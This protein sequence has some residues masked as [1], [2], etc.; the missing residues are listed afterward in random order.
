MKL[1][2][3]G[4]TAPLGFKASGINCG[5]KRNNK[6]DLALIYSEVPAIAAAC[7]TANRVQSESIRVSKTHLK[8]NKAQAIIINSGNANCCNGKRGVDDAALMT[9]LT[10]S[11]LKLPKEYV[12]VASTGLI[13]R[14]LPIDKI[15]KAI[16]FL[17][18]ELN[19]NGSPDAAEA[20]MTTD[21][22]SKEVAVEIK[23]DGFKIN[24]GGIAKGAGMISPELATMLAFFTTDAFID[25]AALKKIFKTSVDKSFNSITVDGDMSTND[26]AL[27]F[28][29]GLANNPKIDKY[30]KNS[31]LFSDAL[32][33]VTLELAK[34][35]VRDGEGATKFVEVRVKGVR[36]VS[37][38]KKIAFKVANS[39][40]VKTALFGC[41]PNWGR[42]VAAVG[43]SEVKFK[44]KNL[45]DIYL[46]DELVL[47]NGYS[48][49]K[50]VPRLKRIFQKDEICITIDLKMG[51][52]GAEV[53]TCDL[54]DEYVRI[55]AEYE[56]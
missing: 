47:K 51:K 15:K 29:N 3:G 12:L 16:P 17:I 26:M 4:I 11:G 19:N 36:K 37:D 48:L 34:K 31:R 35:I 42:I 43:A 24:I 18:K 39:N 13:G 45:V 40:L 30:D 21:K 25:I 54:S 28:A 10:A 33:Y 9:K 27:I 32:D 49:N 38:A 23:I 53:F 44:D 5:L 56:S 46:G 6:K 14:L 41:D 52:F 22:V 50:K 2:S 55:N 7:F 20:I 1:I 8:N